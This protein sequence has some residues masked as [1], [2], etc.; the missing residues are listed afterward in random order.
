[1]FYFFKKVLKRKR[2]ELILKNAEGIAGLG[3]SLYVRHV[4]SG[5]CNACEV[6]VAAL[7]NPHYSIE[8]FGIRFVASPKHAD[9][10]LVTGCVTRNMLTA[11]KKAY[12]NTPSP[13]WVITVGDC[14]ESCPFFKDSY[15]VEGPVSKHIP[16]HVHVPGCPPEPSE[17]ISGFIRLMNLIQREKV[18]F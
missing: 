2:R 4:D 7:G 15:S 9:V 17:I 1:M 12:D 16:V 13:K 11:L 18:N 6:E 3:K 5:S 10:L 14:T 8:S